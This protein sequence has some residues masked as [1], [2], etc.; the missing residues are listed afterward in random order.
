MKNTF[1]F[2]TGI[3]LLFITSACCKATIED[4]GIIKNE[5]SH[6]LEIKRVLNG[7]EEPT[8]IVA[9]FAKVSTYLLRYNT[10]DSIVV[11]FDRSKSAVHYSPLLK[12]TNNN[13]KAIKADDLRSLYNEKAYAIKKED[14]SCGSSSTTSTFTF[15][16]QDYIDAS[17]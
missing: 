10:E 11:S 13:L 16:E 14:Y 5:T 1:N 17:K 8:L 6:S 9:P 12:A 4:I 2:I 15:V 7:F 3:I